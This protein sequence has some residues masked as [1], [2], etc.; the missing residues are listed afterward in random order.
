[1]IRKSAD[2]Q[3]LFK[4]MTFEIRCEVLDGFFKSLG[5]NTSN[6]DGLNAHGIILDEVHELDRDI[7]DILKQSTS[8]RRQWLINM[9]TT[10][11]TRRG[12]LFDDL[13]ENMK[14]VALGGIK[15][16]TFLPL[17]YQLDDDDDFHDESVWVKANPAIDF[18]K[19]RAELRAN[20]KQ[21]GVDPAFE[22]T[23]KVKDFNIIGVRRLGW[24]SYRQYNNEA[25]FELKDFKN[26]L[27]IIGIDLSKTTDMTAISFVAWDKKKGEW[28]THQMYWM[29]EEFYQN[30]KD[31]EIPYK[32]WFEQGYIRISGQHSISYGDISNYI[33][34]FFKNTGG[35]F[36][37]IYYDSWSATY[38]IDELNRMGFNDCVPVQQGYKTLSLPMQELGTQFKE[39]KINYQNNPITK[40]CLSNT[41]V[42]IDCNGNIKPKKYQDKRSLKIDG[43]A[44]LIDAF[45]GVLEHIDNIKNY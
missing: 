22:S 37:W 11:G 18:I 33:N 45:V 16:D 30:N 31:G 17:L 35:R 39:G 43:T 24:L 9:I 38:L 15:N 4:P 8:A 27:V 36:G 25:T 3:E 23:V 32:K 1:M 34:T 20:V 2:L 12:G 14:K 40:W 6:F 29:T 26:K 21:I 42:D 5:K 10:A 28:M 41:E 7:Y 13:Y 44:V 19:S